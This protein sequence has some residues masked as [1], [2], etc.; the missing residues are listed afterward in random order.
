MKLCISLVFLSLAGYCLTDWVS[1][2]AA[3]TLGILFAI[4][5]ENPFPATSRIV[6]KYLLQT[7]VALLGFSMNFAILFQASSQGALFAAASIGATF[8]LGNHLRRWLKIPVQTS[9]LISA[10]TA[11]CGGSAIAAVSSVIN[12]AES[13]ISIAMGTVFVLN[14]IALYIFPILGHALHLT[15]TQ[16]GTWAGISIHDI[17]SVIGAASQFGLSALDTATAVKLSRSLWIIPICLLTF[18]ILQPLPYREQRSSV[19]IPWFIGLFFLASFLRTVLPG[20]AIVIPVI[21]YLSKVGLS[22]V[23]FLVGANLSRQTLKAV[24]L[25]PMLQGVLLW[26]FISVSSLCL[27]IKLIP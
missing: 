7:C 23:L 18:K 24:G 13:E 1:P 5:L 25:K 4:L 19:Q 2:A 6:A 15:P 9:L 27:T 14:A 12:A 8:W 22:L 20:I 26:V 21:S 10:G 17:S 3:L 11:I 16:F